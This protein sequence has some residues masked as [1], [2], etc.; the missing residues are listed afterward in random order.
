M[1]NNRQLL[2]IPAHLRG[3]FP[4]TELLLA[5][6]AGSLAND[7]TSIQMAR[8][9]YVPE[10][11]LPQRVRRAYRFGPP[12]ELIATDGSMP[13]SWLY[14]AELAETAV[15]EAQFCKN[16]VT[17]PGTFFFDELAVQQGVIAQ[18]SFPR[19]L[20]LWDLSGS[21]CSRLG[22]YDQLSSPDYEWCQWFGYLI[23]QA[24]L[25]A[26][27]AQRPDGFVYPSRR[28]RNHTAVA[29]SRRSVEELRAGTTW[30]TVPFSKSAEY[31]QLSL[32]SLLVPPPQR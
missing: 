18:L 20:R 21:I 15:W 28:H 22:I 27:P 30:T 12:P 26:E 9:A 19:R 24:I 32:D 6:L 23:D 11:I 25:I 1:T 3:S 14:V 7:G 8:A 13:F 29:I 16:D 2:E 4:P 31:A 5:G 17:R 10:A